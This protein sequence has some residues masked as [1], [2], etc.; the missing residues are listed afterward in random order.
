M[1]I[2]SVDI[3]K[4]NPSVYNPRK[5]LK[6]TDEEYIK[7]KRSIIN[8]GYVEPILINK[9]MTVIGGHQRLKVLKDLEFENVD[10]VIVDLD[11]N[12][13]KALNVALNKISGD[14]DMDKLS[15]LLDELKLEEIDLELTGFDLEEIENL[16]LWKDEDD[17]DLSYDEEGETKEKIEKLIIRCESKNDKEYIL[18]ELNINKTSSVVSSEIL[19]KYMSENK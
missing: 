3:N 5:D 8:F 4:L 14:W 17:L 18:K 2:K 9:D 12:N 10:C 15:D 16:T 19:I 7:L 1:K 11:K 13:E 6:S